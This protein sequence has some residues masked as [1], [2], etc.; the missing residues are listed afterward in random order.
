MAGSG[1][2]G[3]GLQRA[4]PDQLQQQIDQSTIDTNRVIHAE[5]VNHALAERLTEYNDRDAEAVQGRLGDIRDSIGGAIRGTVDLRFGGSVAK[6]TY[7][8]GLSDIDALA[9][10]SDPSL[11]D[12]GPK[13]ALARFKE[14]LERELDPSYGIKTGALAVTV[15]YPDGMTVQVLPAVRGA[16]GLQIARPGTNLWSTIHPEAFA[17]KL[18]DANRE[19]G[20]LL[21][22][23]IKLAKGALAKISGGGAPAGYHVESMAIEAFKD[24]SGPRT[25]KAALTHFFE[26]ASQ[27]VL[28]PIVDSTGQSVHVDGY[29]GAAESPKRQQ[30]SAALDRIARRL[31]NAD[32]A[33]DSNRWME[34]I[35]EF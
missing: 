2:T 16:D 26:R 13:E 15:T 20:N 21:V 9:I 11:V 7:V 23:T 28:R 30:M 12:L 27:L 17:R 1:G 29:L 8:E 4:R 31:T 3:G 32:R 5:R 6:G 22:P 35:G 10:L 33:T 14:T 24:F 34:T 25:P 19:S 18:T